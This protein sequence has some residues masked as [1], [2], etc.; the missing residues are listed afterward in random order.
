MNL[1]YIQGQQIQFAY[2]VEKLSKL[3]CHNDNRTRNEFF[4]CGYSPERINPGDKNRTK[5]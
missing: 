4:F 2:D 1:P 3:K 5:K